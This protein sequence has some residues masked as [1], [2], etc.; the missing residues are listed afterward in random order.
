MAGKPTPEP[1][2]AP[3]PPQ[4]VGLQL[5]DL[6]GRATAEDLAA[7]D[8]QI[9][10]REKDLA[11]LRAVRRV[12]ALALG[13]E[14]ERKPGPPKGA[15]ARASAGGVG[16]PGQDPPAGRGALLEERRVR[17]ARYLL[18]N[19]PTKGA[20]L[21]RLF[22]IPTGSQTG[23]LSCDWFVQT[24]AGYELSPLGRAAVQRQ[25]DE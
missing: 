18:K 15:S 4:P 21:C 7:V 5:V 1:A 3:A 22:T 6:V 25:V 16:G 23:V 2:P 11:S 17:C 12:L 8:G 19:G 20:E 10:A 9:A 14:Q 13:V 24:D